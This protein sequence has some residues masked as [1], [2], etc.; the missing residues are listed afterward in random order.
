[1]YFRELWLRCLTC[2]DSSVL[3]YHAIVDEAN[4][5]GRLRCAWTFATQQMQ[6]TSCQYSVLAVLYELAQMR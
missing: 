5:L 2:S 6:N 3:Q 1:M 4:V